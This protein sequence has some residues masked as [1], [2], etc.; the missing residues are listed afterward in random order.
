MFSPLKQR[1][2]GGLC[3][4]SALLLCVSAE[5][6]VESRT[7]MI[8][9]L[10]ATVADLAGEGRSYLGRLAGEQTVLSVQKVRE[11]NKEFCVAVCG[12]LKRIQ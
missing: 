2:L 7:G 6:V 1:A 4:L 10:R 11:R 5:K 12:S 8:Q 3:V 9:E